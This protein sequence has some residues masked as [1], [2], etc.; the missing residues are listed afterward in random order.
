[1][2][3]ERINFSIENDKEFKISEKYYEEAKN[4]RLWFEYL[5]LSPTFWLADKH[6]KG[7]LTDEDI[8]K[9]PSDFDEVLNTYS[10]FRGVAQRHFWLWW[11]GN[12][13]TLFGKVPIYKEENHKSHIT[14]VARFKFGGSI[15][16]KKKCILATQKYLDK[17]DFNSMHEQLLITIPLHTPTQELIIQFKK[18]IASEKIVNQTKSEDLEDIISKQEKTKIYQTYGKR[19]RYDTLETGLDLLW[20][21]AKHPT[22]TL[23]EAG[24]MIN[25]S[26]THKDLVIPKSGKYKSYLGNDIITVKTITSRAKRNALLVMENAA[27]GRFPCKDEIEVP[28]INFQEMWNGICIREK[29]NLKDIVSVRENPSHAFSHRNLKPL[30]EELFGYSPKFKAKKS[31]HS[32]N[33]IWH[34]TKPIKF[35]PILR[36]SDIEE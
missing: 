36:A 7:L 34:D 18:L 24:V 11:F 21:L 35:R 20:T 16:D 13:R 12:G 32:K 9:L 17:H 25:I 27:R 14:K 31:F 23:D 8:R 29:N 10:A 28:I 30:Y 4:Y 6:S 15:A 26:P 5:R 1:M 3:I 2:S 22:I 19:I 33:G